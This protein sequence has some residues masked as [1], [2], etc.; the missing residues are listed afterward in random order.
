MKYSKNYSGRR[1]GWGFK[2]YG[3]IVGVK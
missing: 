2:D 3:E 1:S